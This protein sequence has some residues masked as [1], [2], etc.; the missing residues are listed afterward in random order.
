MTPKTFAENWTADGSIIHPINPERLKAYALK[1]ETIDFL[2][3]GLPESA[4]PFLGFYGD[5]E[6]GLRIERLEDYYDFEV[7]CDKYIV[8]GSDGA[9]NPIAI[10]INENDSV[11]LLDHE[12]DFR[13]H[14]AMHQ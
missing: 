12:D 5:A 10:N 7:K 2:S 9:A 6:D 1:A 8:I 11:E 14:I 4:A 13:L 3:I